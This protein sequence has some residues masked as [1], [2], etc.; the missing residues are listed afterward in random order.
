MNVKK[1]FIP[2]LGLLFTLLIFNVQT[3]V[4]NSV[5]DNTNVVA[6]AAENDLAP[7]VATTDSNQFEKAQVENSTVILQTVNEAAT[8]N[9]LNQVNFN[10]ISATNLDVNLTSN[11]SYNPAQSEENTLNNNNNEAVVVQNS[12]NSVVNYVSYN[13][14]QATNNLLNDNNNVAL[15]AG[16][17]NLVMNFNNAPCNVQNNAANNSNRP[18]SSEVARLS[19]K[20]DNLLMT[21]NN[22]AGNANT[23]MMKRLT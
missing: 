12:N 3:N 17:N 8:Q 5:N 14:A 9:S 16:N 13:S 18:V 22:A 7:P 19:D 2:L 23:N 21:H 6:M 15:V 4:D 1:V 10:G 20:N 11:V